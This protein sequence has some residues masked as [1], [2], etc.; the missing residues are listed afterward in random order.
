MSFSPHYNKLQLKR[1]V[2]KGTCC[3]CWGFAFHANLLM[4]TQEIYLRTK[5]RN[6]ILKPLSQGSIWKANGAN[7]SSMRFHISASSSGK[8]WDD[9]SCQWQE[10]SRKA[11]SSRP[12]RC[13]QSYFQQHHTNTKWTN[14]SSV[15]FSTFVFCEALRAF[16]NKQSF[17]QKLVTYK[18]YHQNRHDI[19]LLSEG[20]E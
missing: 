14:C 18:V 16:H 9:S 11:A 2:P 20:L 13:F 8:P 15:Y 5:S 1:R 6:K 4:C 19:S 10:S 7:A 17:F 12:A 3:W